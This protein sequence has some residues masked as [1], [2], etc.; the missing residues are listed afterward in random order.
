MMAA[1]GVRILECFEKSLEILKLG[2]QSLFHR[3]ED[4]FWEEFRNLETFP[5]IRAFSIFISWFWEEFRN[6]ETKKDGEIIIRKCVRF[7]EEF[8]N[9]ETQYQINE[10]HYYCAT[11][12]WEEF[13]NLETYRR[14]FLNMTSSEFWEEFRNLETRYQNAF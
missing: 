2:L 4:V 8:R 11:W 7:W 14:F 5:L 13:R 12:F 6:L 3:K 9:L 1:R 10:D